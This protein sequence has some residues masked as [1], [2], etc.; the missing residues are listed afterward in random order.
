[1]NVFELHSKQVLHDG[2]NV[3]G[4]ALIVKKRENEE[5][6]LLFDGIGHGAYAYTV[7]NFFSARLM[8]LLRRNEVLGDA[9][10]M[11]AESMKNARNANS[12]YAAFTAV[13]VK[14]S[15]HYSIY[16]FEAPPPLL[17]SG[18]HAYVMEGE[19]F[20]SGEVELVNY[21]GTLQVGEQIFICSDGIAQAGLGHGYTGG[22]GMEGA[23]RF[24]TD[25]LKKY[26]EEETPDYNALL[27]ELFEYCCRICAGKNEDDI[28]AALLDY[29]AGKQMLIAT[30]P[31][32]SRNLDAEFARRFDEFE[33]KKVI[34]GSTTIDVLTR[35]LGLKI[36][37]NAMVYPNGS[38]PEYF[39]DGV[40]LAS[41]GDYMLNLVCRYLRKEP[42]D[43]CEAFPDDRLYMMLK[44]YDVIFFYLGRAE[45]SKY[46][47]RMF[48]QTGLFPRKE[49]VTQ[50]TKILR[51]MGKQVIIELF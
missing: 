31:P 24:L 23:A 45:N 32:M 36:N 4:D 39:I 17:I 15:G 7:A 11:V 30:G 35:E 22:I 10:C 44:E 38:P 18:N 20:T 42:S 26:G 14:T 5:F 29:R 40:E 8:E 27:E 6:Y 13:K 41:E 1:M 49:I 43:L 9:C 50:L 2:E 19:R 48:M 34:C 51:A 3:S 12:P 47:D 28:T 25:S 46:S 21:S 16:C 37:G 33:G